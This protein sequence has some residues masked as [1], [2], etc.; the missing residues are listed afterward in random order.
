[1]DTKS[2]TVAGIQ[3]ESDQVQQNATEILTIAGQL[4][5]MVAHFKMCKENSVVLLEDPE[6]VILAS[7][8]YHTL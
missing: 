2:E 8:D 3:T 6:P 4:K 1:L 7:Q 5:T